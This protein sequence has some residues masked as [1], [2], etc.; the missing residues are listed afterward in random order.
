MNISPVGIALIKHF[1]GC[2][3]RAYPDP[4]TGGKPWTIGW[5]HTG[6]D[7]FQGIQWTQKYADEMLLIDLKTFIAGVNNLLRVSVKQCEFDALVSF[8]Y[9]CGLDIDDDTKAEGLGDS[10]LLKKVNANDMAGAALEFGKWISKGTAV[11]K[12]LRRRREAERLLFTGGDWTS[13]E[14]SA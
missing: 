10:T 5:G 2:H 14:P 9:N 6:A 7:V 4:K 3:L 1:E 8:A 13:Y 11:E 12:G